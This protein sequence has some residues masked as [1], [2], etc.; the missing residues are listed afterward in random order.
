MDDLPTADTPPVSTGLTA[1]HL[2][3]AGSAARPYDRKLASV[4]AGGIVAEIADSGWP[5]GQVIGSEADLLARHGVSRAVLR[6]AV[7]LLEH[8]Q[9]ARMRRGPGGGLVVTAPSVDSA[10]D[11]VMV[12]L[13]F[14]EASFAEVF[15]VRLALEL[16]A[17]EMAAARLTEDGIARLRAL[18]DREG[19]GEVANHRELHSLVASVSANPALEL[20]VEVL[21]RVTLVHTPESKEI[22]ARV[23][24]ASADA[25]AKIVES[26]VAGDGARARER[27][28]RH[29][30]A[31]ADFIEQ[32]RPVRPRLDEVFAMSAGSKLA[33]S[34][35]RQL[36]EEIAAS[37][38]TVGQPLGSEP[39][40][41]ERFDVSRAV[42][43]EAVRVLEH[44]GI[45]RM[46]RGPG[47]G[48]FVAEPGVDATVQ[49]L[50]IQLDRRGVRPI[51]VFEVRG[52]IE[53]T[54]L[55]RVIDRLDDPVIAELEAVLEAERTATREAFPVV[56]HDFHA[57]LA[58]VSGNRVLALL[59]EV[60][61]HLSRSHNAVPAGA[62]DPLPTA[63][64]IHA[65]RHIVEAIVSR[66][67]DL[68]RH[69]M[70]RHLD[71]LIRWVR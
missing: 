12:Y 26:I 51:D 3:P 36:F 62:V 25:H 8:Q 2:A 40:L 13:L 64:V 46:R 48:L 61:V 17:A 1:T 37:G 55:N 57:V 21:S 32:R 38:W 66:D 44:H 5:E 23:T 65:H 35:A 24:R 19:R 45:A 15:E 41:M 49:A 11:A 68:A 59:T 22:T 43:R 7:R 27:M 39:E 6:E 30:Q 53:M 34:V 18:I 70:R 52:I 31:E 14:I 54:V 20:F 10:I 42:L 4:V 16:S 33:E 9:V 56:G 58:G 63:D 67:V 29:L 69:R 60:L 71:A 28:R 50:A 47:G